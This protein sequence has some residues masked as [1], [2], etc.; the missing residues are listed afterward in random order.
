MAKEIERSE[1][2]QK[3]NEV[4]GISN[5]LENPS[6][7]ESETNEGAFRHKCGFCGEEIALSSSE[8]KEK[9]FLC[10]ECGRE[11]NFDD[12]DTSK[13]EPD[14]S[15]ITDLSRRPGHLFRTE[16]RITRSEYI[17]TF[18][19]YLIVISVVSKFFD[20]VTQVVSSIALI[21]LP[22]YVFLYWILLAQGSKRCHDIGLSGWFQII[23]FFVFVMFFKD[24]DIGNN[25]YGSDPK[26]ELRS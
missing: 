15:I 9:R 21:A 5:E 10:P 16:G 25:K 13:D 24:S 17:V 12:K 26:R 3:S 2:V 22:V 8:F 11:N 7:P 18:I 14:D 4:D 19:L 1:S 20:S 6:K 23:P